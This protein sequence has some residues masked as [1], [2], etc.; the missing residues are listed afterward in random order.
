MTLLD[1]REIAKLL[2]PFAEATGYALAV[3]D[4][5]GSEIVASRSPNANALTRFITLPFI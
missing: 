2:V 5:A 1:P 3:D 4:P